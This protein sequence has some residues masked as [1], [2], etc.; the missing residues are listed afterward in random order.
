MEDINSILNSGDVTNLYKAEHQE[1]IQSKFRGECVKNKLPPTE[2]NI[3]QFYLA[4]IKANLHMCIAMS[5]INDLFKDR[6]NRFPSFV[7]CTTIDWF[8]A[9]PEDALFGVGKDQLFEYGDELKIADNLEEIVKT[10]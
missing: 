5:P 9:W 6:M 7:N 4:S 10:F 2:M 3:L 8:S 1:Q